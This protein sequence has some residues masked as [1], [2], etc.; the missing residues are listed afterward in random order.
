MEVIAVARGVDRRGIREVEVRL[1]HGAAAHRLDQG[2][3]AQQQR[4]EQRDALHLTERY[5]L[6]DRDP[7]VAPALLRHHAVVGRA[8]PAEAF[9]HVERRAERRRAHRRE[10]ERTVRRGVEGAARS[11]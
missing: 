5:A 11:A 3:E 2:L 4:L 7:I 6:L 9:D 1:A 8:H 10:A